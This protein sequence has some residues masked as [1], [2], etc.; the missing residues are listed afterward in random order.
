MERGRLPALVPIRDHTGQSGLLAVFRRSTA[1][2]TPDEEDLAAALADLAGLALRHTHCPNLAFAADHH[3]GIYEE[4]RQSRARLAWVLATTGIGLWFNELPLGRLNWDEETRWLFFVPPGEDATI[5]LFWSRLHPDDVEPTRAAVEASLRDGSLY[6]ID[7]RAIDPVTG[8][9][10][11]IRSAGQATYTS[12]GTPIRFDGIN[13]D[14]TER[15]RNEEALRKSRAQLLAFIAHAPISIA[16]FDREMRFLA[17]SGRWLADYGRDRSSFVG[18]LIYDA[19]PDLPEKWTAV[20]RRGLAGE[21]L[22]SDEDLWVK[23]DGTEHW[24]SWCVLPW[25]NV[26]GDIGGIIISTED[27]TE[28]KRHEQEIARLNLDLQRRVGELQ[29]ILDTAPMGISITYDPEARHIHGNPAMERMLRL[30]RGS[31]LSKGAP[32][33]LPFSLFRH[34][35]ELPAEALPVQRAVRGETVVGEVLQLTWPDGSCIDL[36]CNAAPL[37]DEEG[38]PRGAVGAFLDVTHLKHTEAALKLSKARFRLLSETAGKL[39][40]SDN[41]QGQVE[42]LC[43]EIMAYLDCQV[44]FNYLADDASGLLHLNACAGIPEDESG[45]LSRLDLNTGVCGAAATER[46]AIVAENIGQ[47]SDPGTELLR[48]YGVQAYCCHPLIASGRLLGTL[49]F[50]TR[51]RAR[52]TPNEIEVMRTVADQVVIA[53]Q[54]VQDLAALRA[55]EERYRSLVEQAVDG[56]FVSDGQGR[57]LD[58]NTAGAS[59]LGYTREEV[60]RLTIP[61]V[62]DPAERSRLPAEIERLREG[63]VRLSE[64]HFLRKDGSIFPGEVMSRRLPDVRLQAILRDITERKET[65]KARELTEQRCK[66]EESFRLYVATQTAA[67]IAHEL[68]QPLTAIASYAEVAL[69]LLRAGSPDP[70]KLEYALENTEKQAQRAG[71]VTRQLMDLLHKGETVTEPVDLKATVEDS[72]GIVRSNGEL[73]CF[74]ISLH[75]AAG[76]APV[77]ANRLQIEKVLVNL[78]RNGLEAMRDQRLRTG[79]ISV[80]VRPSADESLAEVIVRDCGKGLD[81]S[82]LKSIFQTFYTTKPKGLG[83]GLAVSRALIEAHGG[84]LW[85]EPNAGSPG[86]SFHFTLPFAL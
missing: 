16:M 46:R 25:S 54:R 63:D 85:A 70:R 72:V 36:H 42:G 3:C 6:E 48:R 8:E 24:L 68:N 62:I 66:M 45:R 55:S 1:G 82:A 35:V 52:F 71:Q 33:P 67:A 43:S 22:R 9:Q 59:M 51:T 17:A 50:G 37:L 61:D 29:T 77:Q 12:D 18:E 14:I 60:L 31:E 15:K 57:Y 7:H 84:K 4:L 32:E 41:P 27:I 81:E 11:W 38:N 39:L 74:S 23:E 21:T 64:W 83:M 10:R 73:G 44:F 40:A 56:I 58:V 47:T 26:E 79:T 13:F 30:P 28:R 76:L 20:H 49:S 80:A 65:E 86:A 69:F 19:H 2:L 34:G 78:L 75:I 53:F 5:D